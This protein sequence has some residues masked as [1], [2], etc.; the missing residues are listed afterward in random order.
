[1]LICIWCVVGALCSGY[2][3]YI[4]VVNCDW[5]AQYRLIYRYYMLICIYQNTPKYNSTEKSGIYKLIGYKF[6]RW[7]KVQ[8]TMY[9]FL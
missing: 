7:T 4:F 3:L 6:G 2:V 8:F 1:M 5:F 9:L